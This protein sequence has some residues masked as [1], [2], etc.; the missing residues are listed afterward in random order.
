MVFFKPKPPINRDEYEWMIAC[1]AW[2]RTVLDDAQIRPELVLP[3]HPDL[4]ASLAKVDLL[5]WN[6]G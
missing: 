3:D 6:F 4:R 5:E 2:L 1:F